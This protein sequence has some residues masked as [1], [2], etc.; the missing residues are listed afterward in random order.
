MILLNFK[1]EIIEPKYLYIGG[2]NGH[3]AL[4]EFEKGNFGY[5]D[6]NGKEYFYRNENF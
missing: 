1:N 5:I 2:I 6:I 4:V 3:Y